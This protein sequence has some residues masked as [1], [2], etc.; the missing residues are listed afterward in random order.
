M[1]QALVQAAH[2]KNTPIHCG[3]TASSDTFY[4]G[5]N[6]QDSFQKGF[7]IR[8]MR[9]KIA[10]LQGLG[11]LSFE[12]EAATILTQASCYGLRAG[13]I[14]GVLVNRH[15][16]EFPSEQTVQQTEERVIEVAIEALKY[17]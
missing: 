12:M 1:V 16:N 4:Q 3:V 2:L 13:C 17:L 6:R 15:R 11:V 14:L 7:V 8:E 9:D 5:Q 10:E